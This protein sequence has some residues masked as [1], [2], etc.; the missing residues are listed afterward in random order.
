MG[1]MQEDARSDNACMHAAAEVDRVD[2]AASRLAAGR[3]L[4]DPEAAPESW[5][6]HIGPHGRTF[7]H[8]RALGP[9]P[10]LAEGG[11]SDAY[12][13]SNVAVECAEYGWSTI[14][15]RPELP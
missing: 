4:L 3:P 13:E 14:P 15:E 5:E 12:S 11:S 9:A 7:W 8:N 6:Q 1:I 2:D 10:W